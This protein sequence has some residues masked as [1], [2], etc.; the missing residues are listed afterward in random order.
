MTYETPHQ[1]PAG[2]WAVSPRSPE[3]IFQTCERV[4]WSTNH[5]R[6]SRRIRRLARRLRR[7]SQG[8]E[9]HE[10]DVG[11]REGRRGGRLSVETR[12]E[13]P[14]GDRV[15]VVSIRRDPAAQKIFGRGCPDG[16]ETDHAHRLVFAL[17]RLSHPLQRSPPAFSRPLTGRRVD[18]RRSRLRT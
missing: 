15:E 18:L 10:V 2:H 17:N 1:C 4:T 7:S 11:W 14:E 5:A 13:P 8:R 12:R 6:R 16:A 9:S 3:A